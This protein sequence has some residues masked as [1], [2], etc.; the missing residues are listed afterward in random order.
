MFLQ[1]WKA[2]DVKVEFWTNKL[3]SYVFKFSL[4]PDE[5]KISGLVRGVAKCQQGDDDHMLPVLDFE[6]SQQYR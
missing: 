1:Q 6:S 3:Q 2:E 5:A 4:F